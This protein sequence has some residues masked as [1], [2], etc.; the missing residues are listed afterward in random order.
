MLQFITIQLTSV[1][2]VILENRVFVLVSAFS[3]LA[4]FF[5]S[6]SYILGWQLLA[7]F[8]LNITSIFSSY[9]FKENIFV[10][11]ITAVCLD[12]FIRHTSLNN[13]VSILY[14]KKLNDPWWVEFRSEL[15]HR[16][17]CVKVNNFFCSVSWLILILLSECCC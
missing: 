9:A 8:I 13:L 15:G 1:L 3:I 17:R 10:H 16:F 11:V 6:A 5:C 12:F 4:P 2:C 7:I 14:F